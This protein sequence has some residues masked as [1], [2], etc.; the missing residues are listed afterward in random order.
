MT[1]RHVTNAARPVIVVGARAAGGVR[2]IPPLS[3]SDFRDV[4]RTED[5]DH[6]QGRGFGSSF[7][8]PRV[9]T[10]SN[11]NQGRGSVAPQVNPPFDPQ[12]ADEAV[13]RGFGS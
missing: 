12:S 3:W 10:G 1:A 9:D 5:G 8:D 13:G 4:N 11:R 2:S 6:A 7:A